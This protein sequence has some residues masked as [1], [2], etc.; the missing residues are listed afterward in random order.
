MQRLI[1][2]SKQR[3]NYD[4][5]CNGATVGEFLRR[6]HLSCSEQALLSQS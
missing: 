3:D 2:T 5:F 4:W 1:R 6:H